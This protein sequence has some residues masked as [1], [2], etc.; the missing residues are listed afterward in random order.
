MERLFLA[1]FQPLIS[2]SP[3]FNQFQSAYRR[4][5]S[6]ET[7]I[8]STLDKI[9]HSADNGK[10]T[11]LVYLDLSA[12]FDTID[13]RILIKRLETSFGVSATVFSW[14][15]SYL[16]DRQQS[17]NVGGHSSPFLVCDSGVPQGSVLGPI[18]FNIYTSPVSTICSFH[19]IFQQQYADDTQL[20]I[21]LSPFC[22]SADFSKLTLCLSSLQHWFS[23]NGLALNAE[24][25]ESILLGTRQRS[26][27]YSNV[28]S[29][30]VADATVPLTDHVK[31]LGVT[32]DSHLTFDKHVNSLSKTCFYHIR[33]FRHI[34]PAINE[35]MA[36][37]VACSL[38]GSCLDY[39]NSALYGVSKRNIRRLQRIQNS[40]ARVV[41]G[42]TM[43]SS[44]GA[45]ATLRRL[46]WLPIEWRIQHKI[47]TLAFKARS[48][49][50]P[51][52]L[53]DLI[54]VYAPPRLLRSSVANL[55]S[56]PSHKL[57]FGSRAFRVAA[58]TI[59]NSLS[60]NIRMSESL[61]IFRKRLKT[62]FFNCAY[63]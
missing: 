44:S 13:H 4:H 19:G 14:L 11:I 63:Q 24:K 45:T 40:V 8:L 2:S 36:K 54:S 18:L 49:E 5:H 41:V 31:L 55:L 60:E 6:T 29:V 21:A 30:N 3:N 46:H 33:A 50:A 61:S 22:F 58:P 39:A 53:R 52:Y 7:A 23:Q 35:D 20:F 25:S 42:S 1:R 47:A 10:S 57:T 51:N 48:A 37:L 9:F 43:Y 26:P 59:W 16:T 56:V 62:H 38:V 15:S 34:R 28:S 12:A 17:V 32:L 27:S